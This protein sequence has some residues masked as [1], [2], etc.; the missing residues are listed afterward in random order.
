MIPLH[1]R[2][3]PLCLY[4]VTI[5]ISQMPDE[6]PKEQQHD[7]EEYRYLESGLTG[8]P[9]EARFLASAQ[10]ILYEEPNGKAE[11]RHLRQHQ[12]PAFSSFGDYLL[13]LAT[14]SEATSISPFCRIILPPR[15]GK[16][17]VAGRIIDWAGLCSTIVVPTKA[18]VH[19]T[20]EELRCQIPGIPMGLYY[21]EIKQPV[22][23]GVNITTYATLQSHFSHGRL[24]ESIRRSA[25]IFLDEAHH[26]ITSLRMGTLQNA[27]EAKAI[28][29]ALTATPDYDHKRRLHQFFPQLIHEIDLLTAF[30]T[31]LLAPARMWVAE[32]DV[33]ASVVRFVAGD[34]ETETL[35]RLMSSSPFFKA[36]EV[37]RYSG[38]NLNIPAIVACASRQQ[39]YD[40]WTYFQKHRP[41][42]QPMPGLILGD[43]PSGQRQRLLR[44][45]ET[46]HTDTLIQVGVLI[47]GWNAPRCKLLLDLAPSLSRVRATQKYFRVM[48]R[49]QGQEARIFVILPKRL[50]R[51]P[52]LPTDLLL[53]PGESY[54]CGD[55]LQPKNEQDDKTK[56]PIDRNT[57]TPIKSVVLKT[58]IIAAASL[59]RPALNPNNPDEILQVLASCPDFSSSLPFGRSGF[60]NL[61]FGHPLFIGTGD[62]LL[63][64]L[65]V[66][67]DRKAFA[68]FLAGLFPLDSGNQVLEGDRDFT[69]EIRRSCLEDFEDVRQAALA[70]NDNKG[71][72]IEPYMGVLRALC[73]GLREIA[74]PEEIL[75]IREQIAQVLLLMGEL[76][77]RQQ[78]ILIHRLGLFGTS[79]STW[80]AIGIGLGISKERVRQIFCKAI[81]VLAHRYRTRARDGQPMTKL[82]LE[83]PNPLELIDPQAY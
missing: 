66:P 74:S 81:R 23:H 82:F 75:L 34:Y 17:V 3:M 10:R 28:R 9:I 61:V 76:Q 19:Q 21:S 7:Q 73:G 12:I 60:R 49:H 57:H 45:F 6:R 46:G 27:F 13:D 2:K 38:P 4:R 72:P 67:N 70:P 35:G 20:L 43:T 79:E 33:D 31:G 52:I 47:E 22:S 24:P 16:T 68:A 51:L 63:R 14:G 5:R 50:P 15:T 30:E 26:T 40:L 29:V 83:Y 36:V 8:L 1:G 39:A 58:R 11:I 48:T 42:S 53:K 62:A 59:V 54:V 69:G 64:F 56:K 78:Y 25:L 55:L 32:V 77:D 41:P 80:D 18:L 37:F 71:K 65:G 44:E